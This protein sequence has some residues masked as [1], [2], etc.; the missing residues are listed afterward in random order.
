MFVDYGDT[1]G[2]F[3]IKAAGPDR[4]IKLDLGLILGF[5]TSLPR[6]LY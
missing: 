4:G 6:Q 2:L 5:R 1:G 3:V